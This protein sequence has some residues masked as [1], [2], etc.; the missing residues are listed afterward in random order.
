MNEK[1]RRIH[2]QG[3][4]G[5]L[6]QLHDE[7]DAAVAEAYS[8]PTD[9][10]EAEILERLVQL[11]AQRV[12]EEAAGQVRWLRP[13]YQAPY[14]A[15]V[16]TQGKLIADEEL[17]DVVV[18]SAVKRNWPDKLPEQA[19][20]LRDL[21]AALEQPADINALAAAFEGKSSPKRKTDIQRLLETMAAL[22]QAEETG[23]GR[24]KR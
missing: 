15:Q 8:W 19:A 13:E 5:L 21:L 22:G 18:V 20:A 12:T 10:P 1:E 3:L 17:P 2:D 6:R 16:G 14:A 4:V 7:L 11:N 9:L 24:W 23:S